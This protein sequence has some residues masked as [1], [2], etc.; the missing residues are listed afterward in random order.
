MALPDFKRFL[1]IDFDALSSKKVSGRRL[2]AKSNGCLLGII[3]AML[4][5]KIH[6]H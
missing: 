2:S 4:S 1:E 5:Y 3:T 6:R